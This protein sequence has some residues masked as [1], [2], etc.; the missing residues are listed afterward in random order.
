MVPVLFSLALVN[1]AEEHPFF[2][3]MLLAVIGNIILNVGVGGNIKRSHH[4]ALRGEER[5]HRNA[6]ELTFCGRQKE[7]NKIP[8]CHVCQLSEC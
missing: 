3:F 1:P 2:G 4:A 5:R 7:E 6:S 8:T